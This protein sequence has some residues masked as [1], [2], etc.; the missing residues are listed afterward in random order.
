[1]TDERRQHERKLIC[2]ETIRGDFLLSV[3]G[4]DYEFDMVE[5]VSITGM[6]LVLPLQL[7][8]GSNVLLSYNEAGDMLQVGATVAWVEPIAG[9]SDKF[10][11][12]VY[13]DTGDMDANVLFFMTLREY[14]DDFGEAF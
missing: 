3:D 13:F 9:P 14:I 7:T 2:C 12:G 8:Q 10:R 1:M 4:I 6:G 11:T 5:D